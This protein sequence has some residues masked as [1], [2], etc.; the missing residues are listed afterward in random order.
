MGLGE[1]CWSPEGGCVCIAGD[2]SMPNTRLGR[3]KLQGLIGLSLNTVFIWGSVGSQKGDQSG[4]AWVLQRLLASGGGLRGAGDS[5]AV[6]V[7]NESGWTG[8]VMGTGGQR[9]LG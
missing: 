4:Q 7:W 6:T 8:K 9:C 5:W 2:M 3:F 1:M